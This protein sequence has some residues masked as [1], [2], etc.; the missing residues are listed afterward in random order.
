MDVGIIRNRCHTGVFWRVGGWK[1]RGTHLQHVSENESVLV[2]AGNMGPGAVDCKF[3]VQRYDDSVD[4]SRVGDA[5]WRDF[6]CDGGQGDAIEGGSGGETKVRCS[7]GT[8]FCAVS[9]GCADA[10][11]S[12]SGVDGSDASGAGD[13]VGW[14]DIGQAGNWASRLAEKWANGQV[15]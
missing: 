10:S 4:T 2:S 7:T 9:R 12:C 6:N 14:G 1:S 11:V 13:G 15:G 3:G 8:G 5:H